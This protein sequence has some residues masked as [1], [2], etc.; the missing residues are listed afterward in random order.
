MHL[1]DGKR[2]LCFNYF[3]FFVGLKLC[4]GSCL[5]KASAQKLC[6]SIYSLAEYI[7]HFTGTEFDLMKDK[8]YEINT[9]LE[10]IT[11]KIENLEARQCA[12]ENR[13]DNLE[14]SNEQVHKKLK[15]VN[16]TIDDHEERITNF[17]E[18]VTKNK[19]EVNSSYFYTP[20]RTQHFKGRDIELQ[21]M[22]SNLSPTSRGCNMISICGVGGNG[23]STLAAEFCFRKKADYPGGVFWF[24]VDDNSY[25]ETSVNKLA[26]KIGVRTENFEEKLHHILSWL[27]ERKMPWILVLDNLDELEL[28]N[29]MNTIINGSWKTTFYSSGNI[30]IT[31]RRKVEEMS[32]AVDDLSVD[33]CLQLNCFNV[34]DGISF[35]LERTGKHGEAGDAQQLVEELG[36]LPLALEQAASHIKSVNVPFSSYLK[37]Y[38]QQRMKFLNRKKVKPVG[39]LPADKLAVI[40]TWIINFEYVSQMSSEYGYGKAAAIV[41]QVAGYLG[42]DDIPIEVINKGDPLL[43][44]KDLPNCLDNEVGQKEIIEILTKF[45]L[46]QCSNEDSECVLS[47]HRLVQEVIRTNISE[48]ADAESMLRSV[49]V[50]AIRLVNGAFKRVTTPEIILKGPADSS[51]N[52]LRWNQIATHC[53]HLLEHIGAHLKQ[54]PNLEEH[55]TIRKEFVDILQSLKVYHSVCG[56]QRMALDC[57]NHLLEIMPK[58]NFSE[59]EVND[60]LSN[61]NVKLPLDEGQRNV[62]ISKFS[63]REEIPQEMPIEK[64]NDEAVRLKEEG[65]I[66]YKEKRYDVA[67]ELYTKALELATTE[68]TKRD[69]YQNR[70]LCFYL[71]KCHIKS[72]RDANM[73]IKSAYV[74]GHVDLKLA[75]A[76]RRRAYAWLAIYKDYQETRKEV[77]ICNAVVGEEL[78]VKYGNIFGNIN[79]AVAAEF[80]PSFGAELSKLFRLYSVQI[81]DPDWGSDLYDIITVPKLL[82]CEVV[83]LLREGTYTV[84][85][86]NHLRHSLALTLS[87]VFLIGFPG[88]MVNVKID[89]DVALEDVGYFQNIK[90]EANNSFVV[91]GNASKSGFVAFQMCQITGGKCNEDDNRPSCVCGKSCANILECAAYKE[92]LNAYLKIRQQI[93]EENGELDE[94]VTN[95][96]H[97]GIGKVI[98][99]FACSFPKH[100]S[101]SVPP[102]ILSD[103]NMLCQHCDIEKGPS[104]GLA[105]AGR[106]SHLFIEGCRISGFQLTGVH[107]DKEGSLVIMKSKIFANGHHGIFSGLEAMFVRIEDNEIFSNRHQGLFCKN[108]HL[109]NDTMCIVRGNIIHHNDTGVASACVK[110]LSISSNAIFSN[111]LWGIVLQFPQLCS[112]T[113]ND[114]YQNLCGG[115]RVVWNRSKNVIIAKNRIHD[116]IGPAFVA[117]STFNVLEY[118]DPVIQRKDDISVYLISNTLF[119]NDIFHQ[120]F[121]DYGLSLPGSCNF[122]NKRDVALL[123]CGKCSKTCY[124]S[125]DCQRADW[126][127]RHKAFCE[128]YCGVFEYPIDVQTNP[129]CVRLGIPSFHP[130]LQGIGEGPKPDIQGKTKFVIKLQAGDE[131]LE[132]S[133]NLKPESK[134]VKFYDQSLTVS[135]TIVSDKL[136]TFVRQCGVLGCTKYYCKKLYC[137]AKVRERNFKS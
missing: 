18:Y 92:D 73:C 37:Q 121:S 69:L 90:V 3:L 126:K 44:S 25:L 71:Q 120:K 127:L 6:K 81:V 98:S 52:L 4:F 38:K 47:V 11:G 80:H 87:S 104:V 39:Q 32:E 61:E 75:K 66:A 110:R 97:K 68:E 54:L 17:E 60:W 94:I 36:G 107:V 45:S 130:E 131:S 62:L 122:C 40:S 24:T 35:L 86:P 64:K 53:N 116:H 22:K 50:D 113:E 96:K 91:V 112:I 23:K 20:G 83:Y 101:A 109:A 132:S 88:E 1:S 49:L 105:A 19:T 10:G 72:L 95:P 118:T 15:D 70:S 48:N 2:K 34:P 106:S 76:Y 79:A 133:V 103:G 129:G 43:D 59:K 65:N 55:I 42:P 93:I 135:G 114:I 5:E 74:L 16:Q 63:Q 102:V 78:F 125:K 124:C 137:W 108:L 9:S 13:I 85:K 123:R 56:R 7:K 77:E 8:I 46:F 111:N 26:F 82:K 67:V 29:S 33:N 136:F 27:G 14:E 57:Q 115:L 89:D 100:L 117:T 58:L 31:S 51:L 128:L 28:G 84:K 12:S 134:I 99:A 41:M 21:F 30:I 119:R